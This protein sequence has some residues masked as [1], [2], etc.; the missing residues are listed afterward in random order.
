MASIICLECGNEIPEGE[1]FNDY[2]FKCCDAFDRR[3]KLR[4]DNDKTNKK[5]E[6]TNGTM[7]KV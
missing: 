1:A 6:G 4:K 2:C 5:A 3:E 7:P